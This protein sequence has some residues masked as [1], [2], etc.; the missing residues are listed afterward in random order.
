MR[1]LA[2]ISFILLSNCGDMK[3]EDY[4]NTEPKI[5]IEEYFLG[6]VKAWGIFQG[7]TGNVKRQFTADMQGTFDGTILILNEDFSW[8]DGEKQTRQWKIKKIGN[9]H[10]EGT[11]PDVVGIAKG[12]SYG[13]AFKFEYQL[14]IPFQGKKIKVRFDD[15]IFKQ[16]DKV[17]INRAIVTKFGFKVGEL[18]VF[19]LKN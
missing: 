2:I 16:D 8:N 7:R 9:H 6:S 15:W 13:S 12:T 5:K 19:F 4:A 14:L 10:Y 1:F 18:T 11:A 3:T 17:A